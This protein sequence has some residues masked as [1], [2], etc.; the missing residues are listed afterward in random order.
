VNSLQQ[1]DSS[2]SAVPLATIFL[3]FAAPCSK[4][5][6]PQGLKPNIF[7][8]FFGTTEVVTFQNLTFI[9]GCYVSDK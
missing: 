7:H 9:T 4:F 3:L 2:P 8:A 5:S 6:F 1:A